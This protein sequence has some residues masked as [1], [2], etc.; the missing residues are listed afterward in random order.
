MSKKWCENHLK[1]KKIV[2]VFNKIGNEFIFLNYEFIYLN[3]KKNSNCQF[4]QNP[5]YG[6]G[7]SAEMSKE[8]GFRA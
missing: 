2:T 1:S 5:T 7:N 4:K 6:F 8:G 3:C